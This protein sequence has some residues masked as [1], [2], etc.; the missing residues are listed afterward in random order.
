MRLEELL[1]IPIWREGRAALEGMDFLRRGRAPQRE[2]ARGTG[3]PVLLIPGYM[4]GDGSLAPLAGRLRAAGHRPQ[5]AAIAAN[6]DCATRTTERL[7]ERLKSITDAHGERAV[8]IGHSLGGVLGRLLATRRPDLVR[9]VVCLGSPLVTL[10]AVHP[11][12]W[13]HVRLIGALGDLGVPGLMSRSCLTGECCAQ[14]RLLARAPFPGEVGF[15]SV[16]SRRDG[17][18]DWRACLDPEAEHA[19]V[20]SSHVGM[21]INTAVYRLLAERLGDLAQ[22]AGPRAAR[23]VA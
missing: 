1:S 16:Y 9:D 14:S 21:G 15:L 11:L 20:D 3:R 17:I 6:M 8:V 10:D 18:V 4:A 23:A 22:D 12:V 19:E 5:G 7:V 2:M 13:A